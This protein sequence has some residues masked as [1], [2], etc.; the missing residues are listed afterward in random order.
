MATPVLVIESVALAP[1]VYVAS[2]LVTA[3]VVPAF[4][5]ERVAPAPAATVDAPSQQLCAADLLTPVTTDITWT[6]LAWFKLYGFQE[7]NV[8]TLKVAMR[9]Q[10]IEESK[11]IPQKQKVGAN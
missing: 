6:P 9:T 1:V 2:A 5:T 11:A 3:Y 8:E 10:S 7:H 4:V